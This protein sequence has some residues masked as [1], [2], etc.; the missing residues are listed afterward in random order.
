M[1]SAAASLS[2]D[3]LQL[4]CRQSLL[5]ALGPLLDVVSRNTRSESGLQLQYEAV[6][7]IRGCLLAACEVRPH[8]VTC[9]GFLESTER[10]TVNGPQLPAGAGASAPASPGPGP[11]SSPSGSASSSTASGP[12]AAALS[13]VLRGVPPWAMIPGRPVQGGQLL[14]DDTEGNLR[15]RRRYRPL[16]S[17]EHLERVLMVLMQVL[18]GSM[19]RVATTVAE[20]RSNASDF[21]EDEIEEVIAQVRELQSV[22]QEVCRAVGGVSLSHGAAALGP[23]RRTVF[24]AIE[25]HLAGAHSPPYNVFLAASMAEDVVA[26]CGPAVAPG[27]SKIMSI[28]GKGFSKGSTPALKRASV[29][30][31]GSSCVYLGQRMGPHLKQVMGALHPL[32]Q[33]ALARDKA[34]AEKR[35]PFPEP[36]APSVG[37]PALEEQAFRPDPFDAQEQHLVLDNAC[38]ALGKVLHFTVCGGGPRPLEAA[39]KVLGAEGER[40]PAALARSF[41]QSLPLNYDQVECRSAVQLLAWRV[42]LGCSLVLGK[43]GSMVPKLLGIFAYASHKATVRTAFVRAAVGRAVRTLRSKAPAG[44]IEEG[45]KPLP[46]KLKDALEAAVQYSQSPAACAGGPSGAPV[47]PAKGGAAIGGAAGSPVPP[48]SPW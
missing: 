32:V 47:S 25:E 48:G 6:R 45:L 24:K 17:E 34:I 15:W 3:A 21:D 4:A 20:V 12:D 16:L 27:L 44:L 36:P 29:Y 18:R 37:M 42:E 5:M 7:Q 33:G 11:A 28:F 31:L 40:S 13:E 14:Q 10:G 1:C 22:Q 39:V 43:G 19:Q 2:G 23:L 38:S 35:T 46:A 9:E 8:R 26:G 41:V 30:A